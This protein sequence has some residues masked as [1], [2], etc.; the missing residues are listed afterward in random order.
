LPWVKW[1]ERNPQK[2]PGTGGRIPGAGKESLSGIRQVLRDC[3]VA[4]LLATTVSTLPSVPSHQ[5]GVLPYG[6]LKNPL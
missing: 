3:F 6:Q 4:K 2:P 5:G 1:R